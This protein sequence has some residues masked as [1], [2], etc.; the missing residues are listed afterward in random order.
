MNRAEILDAL[1]QG[2]PA[3]QLELDELNPDCLFV[4]A[5]HIPEILESLR[6]TPGLDFNHFQLLTAVD[7][8]DRIE[9]IYYLYS[10]PRKHTVALKAVLDRSDPRIRTVSHLFGTAE[11]HENEAYDLFGVIFE[12][13]PWPRRIFTPDGWEGYPMRK[14]FVH[15]NLVHKPWI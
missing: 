5:S 12:G 14:D 13:H 15:P 3:L 11:W 4:P 9:L 1:K 7:W 6:D 8:R 2:H 10:Y